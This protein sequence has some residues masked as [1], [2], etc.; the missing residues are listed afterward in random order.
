[1]SAQTSDIPGQ[2]EAPTS[3]LDPVAF[4]RNMAQVA[5]QSQRLVGDFLKRQAGKAGTE[6]FDPLN[7]TGAFQAV[8][9]SFAADPSQ[10]LEAQY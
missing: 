8:M 5:S 9:K 7:I 10:I 2:K 6:A 3:S 4:A 1:M